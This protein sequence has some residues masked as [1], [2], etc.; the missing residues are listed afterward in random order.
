MYEDFGAAVDRPSVEFRLFFPNETQYVRGGPPRIRS[1][2]V[3]GSFQGWDAASAPQLERE[4][5]A[6]GALW[7]HRIDE[8]PDGY[9]EYKY[10][11]EMEN[12]DVRWCGDPCSRYGGSE[13]ENS[14]F[15]IGGVKMTPR[16]IAKRKPLRELVIYE[17]MVDDFT[18]AF[19]GDRAPF[20]AIRDRLDYLQQLGI[21]AIEFMPWTAWNNNDFSWGYDPFAFFAVEYRLLNDPSDPLTKLFRLKN[22]IDE[23]HARDMHAIMDGVFN[24][25]VA[26]ASADRGFPYSWLYQNREETPFI[27]AFGGGGFFEDLDFRNA[28]VDQFVF[29]VCRYWL[30]SYQLDGIRFDYVSGFY[31]RTDP[32]TGISKIVGML[33]EA[34]AGQN[35][36]FI[37]EFLTD[38]RFQAIDKTNEI[39]ADGCWFDPIMWQLG[40][41]MWGDASPRLM[42]ALN[43]S[44]DLAG[45]RR[46]ITYIE[47]HDHTTVTV[48]VGGRASWWRTQPAAIA[49]LTA[50]GTPM[51]HNGK[52]FGDDY[53]LPEGG[54]GRV[55]PRPLR[56]HQSDDEIGRA[57]RDLYKRLIAI[58][59][60]HPALRSTNFY[61]DPYDENDR[62]FNDEGYGVD[63]ERGIAI[64]HRWEG[65]ERFII[66]LNFSDAAQEVDV[67][68]SVDGEWRD[69]LNGG[70]IDVH[71]FHQRM[72]LTSHWGRVWWRRE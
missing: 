47:N 10:V 22:L 50:A 51:I 40:D 54:D 57:L 70:S 9:Y 43:A 46:A 71:G 48:R 32:P 66:A 26:G 44:K 38:D 1:L 21:N 34:Y 62:R 13:H 59:N 64:F 27:G 2:R 29:D 65:S 67:P 56:W 23:L 15:V 36:S 45:N 69:L 72:E 37:L 49:L 18:A 33:D 68:F 31:Q 11:A 12:G 25:V 14:A 17:L 63:E 3:A 24:H 6:D 8:L 52:E 30:E 20:D 5:R 53:S 58:R 61:P 35:R 41:A 42:R 28:C 55:A 7:T 60:E 4:E 19:R 39:A 16:A